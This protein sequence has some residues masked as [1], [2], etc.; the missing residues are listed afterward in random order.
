MT[1]GDPIKSDKNKQNLTAGHLA[2]GYLCQLSAVAVAVALL[3][4][5]AGWGQSG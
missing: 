4:T 1:A 2:F 3:L 5:G